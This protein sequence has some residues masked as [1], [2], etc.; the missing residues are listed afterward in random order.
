MFV[1]KLRNAALVVAAVGAVVLASLAAGYVAHQ[2]WTASL[3]DSLDA[4]GPF[5]A[6]PGK[7]EVLEDSAPPSVVRVKDINPADGS[8]LSGLLNVNGTLFF[9]AGSIHGSELWKT[10]LTPSGPVTRLV[11]RINPRGYSNPVYLTN[12]DGT[13][14][15]TADDGVY[16]R[17]LWKS[18]GTEAGT[19]LVKDVNPGRK[20][21]RLLPNLAPDSKIMAVVNRTLYFGADDGVHGRQLWKSDGTD[22]GTQM[23][24]EIAPGGKDA[25][26]GSLTD[27]NGT[28][29][30]TAGDGIHCRKLWK[31]DGTDAGTVPIDKDF[32]PDSVPAKP[33]QWLMNLAVVDGMLFFVAEWRDPARPQG[34]GWD[35]MDRWYLPVPRRCSP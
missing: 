7:V 2:S 28:L 27:V 25:D 4:A 31:S 33:A 18:D 23:V 22:A 34:Q 20:G 8:K 15:F 24:T 19:V 3:P 21:S 13:L 16:G 17:G 11:K 12:V 32:F 5:P 29:Y 30:F 9:S 6:T 26:P 14:F 1:A 35:P 10:C